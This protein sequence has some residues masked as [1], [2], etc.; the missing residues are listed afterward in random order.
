MDLPWASVA[1]YTT[2]WPAE[3]GMLATMS[4]ADIRSLRGQADW[5]PGC[6]ICS[7]QRAPC[8]CMASASEARPGISG[9][10]STAMQVTVGRPVFL[11][12]VEAPQ[13]MKPHPP[14]ATSSW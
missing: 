9:S 13:M 6:W 14:L 12:G 10:S 7:E 8:R 4:V 3:A 11:S 5:R 1:A 2:S